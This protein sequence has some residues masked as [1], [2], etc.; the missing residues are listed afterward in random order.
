MERKESSV[1]TYTKDYNEIWLEAMQMVVRA[2]ISGLEFDRTVKCQI[3]KKKEAGIYIVRESDTLTYEATIAN[4]SDIDQYEVDEWV[5]VLIPSG[6]SSNTKL[7]VG[8]YLRDTSESAIGYVPPLGSMLDMTDNILEDN[9]SNFGG[10]NAPTAGILANGYQVQDRFPLENF[11]VKSLLKDENNNDTVIHL[12]NLNENIAHNH[13]YDTFGIKAS[14]KTM[15]GNTDMI[16]GNYG[17]IVYLYHRDGNPVALTLDSSDMFGNPYNYMSYFTQSKKFDISQIGKI[18]AIG[19]YLYQGDN[20]YYN[21]GEDDYQFSAIQ[22]NGERKPDNILVKDVYI[23][24]GQDLLKI[25]DNTFKLSTYGEINEGLTY[26]ATDS[27]NNER[28]IYATWYN[29]S[30]FNEFIGFE[31]GII[32]TDYSEEDYI[33]QFEEHMAGASLG[34]VEGVPRLKESLQIY[35]NAQKMEN[36]IDS[37]HSRVSRDMIILVQNLSEYLNAYGLETQ[38]ILAD[39][40]ETKLED[41]LNKI[42]IA[43]D[44]V[45]NIETEKSVLD[46]YIE[47]LENALEI[48]NAIKEEDTI[49]TLSNTGVK[50]TAPG[51]ITEL[52]NE[53]RVE[54]ENLVSRINA[55]FTSIEEEGRADIMTYINRSKQEIEQYVEIINTLLTEMKNLVD[56]T[57]SQI[58]N[59]ELRL[60][61]KNLTTFEEEYEAFEK[62]HE[63][64]YCIHWYRKNLTAAGD[65]WSGE[66]WERITFPSLMETPGMPAINTEVAPNVYYKRSTLLY[67]PLLD[68]EVVKDCFKAILFFNHIKHESNILEFENSRPPDGSGDMGDIAGALYL[69]HGL[70]SSDTY[71]KYNS[72]FGLVSASDGMIN[73]EL[74]VR[75]DGAEQKDEAL[76]GSTVY[77]Y[78]PKSHTMLTYD[79]V[80]LADE[81]FTNLA[82]IPA[83]T[84]DPYQQEYLSHKKDKY[85]CFFKGVRDSGVEVDPPVPMSADVKFYYMIA[86]QYNAAYSQNEIICVMSTSDREYEASKV[87]SFSTYGTSGTDFT[88]S[89]VPIG[90]QYAIEDIADSINPLEVKVKFS[91]YNGAEVENPPAITYGWYGVT[92]TTPPHVEVISDEDLATLEIEKEIG[93]I[94][95]RVGKDFDPA[96]NELYYVLQCQARWDK[97]NDETESD[98]TLQLIAYY[99]IPYAFGPYYMD[100]ATTVIYNSSGSKATYA[101]TPYKLFYIHSGEEYIPFDSSTNSDRPL[102]WQLRHYKSNGELHHITECDQSSRAYKYWDRTGTLITDSKDIEEMAKIDSYLPKLKYSTYDDLGN[103]NRIQG[104]HLSPVTMYVESKG[105]VQLYSVAVAIEETFNGTGYDEKMIFAQPIWIGQNQ[106]ESAMLNSWDESLTID[107]KNGT[108]LSTMVGAG[109]KDGQN[110]F[111][112]VLMGNVDKAKLS[113]GNKQGVGLYGFHEGAQSFCWN[114]DGTG[115]IG[116]S[117]R[118]RI[119][120]DG[121]KGTI[122]SATWDF[123]N[124]AGSSGMKIDLDDAIIKMRGV[125]IPDG[126]D[127]NRSEILIQVANPYFKINSVDGNT[128]MYVGDSTMYLQ[129]NDY[130][131]ATDATEDNPAAGMKINLNKGKIDA[132]NF[133]LTTSAITISSN[134]SPYIEIKPS[135]AAQS[136]LKISDSE[137]YLQSKDYDNSSKGVKLNLGTGSITAYNFNITAYNKDDNSKKIIINSGLQSFPLKLG[138]GTSPAF[139]VDWDGHLMASHVTISGNGDQEG[140]TYDS[141]IGGWIIGTDTLKSVSGLI[142]LNGTTGIITCKNSAGTVTF[143]GG[144]S[145][146]YSGG[147]R[148]QYE[149]L[150]VTKTLS[151]YGKIHITNEEYNGSEQAP[152]VATMPTNA[153]FMVSGDTIISGKLLIDSTATTK[154]AFPTQGSGEDATDLQIYV[155]GAAKIDSDIYMNGKLYSTTLGSDTYINFNNYGGNGNDILPA[156]ALHGSYALIYASKIWLG[157]DETDKI[158]MNG[159]AHF[160]SPNTILVTNAD[161]VIDENDTDGDGYINLPSYIKKHSSSLFNIAFVTNNN[162]TQLS[163]GGSAEALHTGGVLGA[164]RTLVAPTAVG[165]AGQFLKATNATGGTEWDD[166]PTPDLSSYVTTTALSSASVSYATSAGSAGSATNATNATYVVASEGNASSNGYG[167]YVAGING[168][169]NRTVYYTGLKVSTISTTSSRRFK[170]N[171]E[172]IE[173]SSLLYKLKPVSFIYN[174]DESERI[175]YGFIAEDILPLN[176]HLVDVEKNGEI[177]ALYYNSIFTLA[178][179]EI[180][181]LRK[182][183]NELKASL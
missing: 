158:Y 15:F 38:K 53:W 164:T 131:S 178:I 10:N 46:Y 22:S 45:D 128:L 80:K 157:D 60:A 108:I 110:R 41:Y 36:M 140:V 166:I 160:N 24:F 141:K 104:Y 177:N 9:N 4:N 62:E 31:D 20:F 117:G 109:Y 21:D 83:D 106:W 125:E 19:I 97:I 67:T 121:N 68:R 173:D 175:R 129:S 92:N 35:A 87:F 7:I 103:V 133:K 172:P 137:Y 161:P 159:I 98:Q 55:L 78:I 82:D 132:Y 76:I 50:Q 153:Q 152:V 39:N 25:E 143:Y 61:N 155:N 94:Y 136:L 1:V 33:T 3:V 58:T 169:G 57:D 17:L 179:A 181:K 93:A 49:P 142:V 102:R 148:A 74:I 113:L 47:Y 8:K 147:Y 99:P 124:E 37:L 150:I 146:G 54:S 182:E 107:E 112:G 144:G 163:F 23:A 138:K 70:N 118:G 122:S 96:N 149:D 79:A 29:K 111:H 30:E 11:K 151:M 56:S 134:G 95:Y 81:G 89:I 86:K 170:H 91:G 69:E 165:S 171:I 28:N 100:G 65:R 13:I 105:D 167:S 72:S 52:D 26:N 6:N 64:R 162:V 2:E 42:I 71:Q 48:Y 51:M 27:S 43:F 120:F 32:D 75:F 114:V 5:Y 126:K 115:F 40:L 139:Q 88:L 145:G 174:N 14:F 16:T 123:N 85:H 63:N 116:K 66:G 127:A 73:R 180:Q 18:D 176:K 135:G 183:L 156:V 90:T 77:W 44:K 168:T 59:F 119:N 130:V 84:A 34:A 154:T 12:D 101:N